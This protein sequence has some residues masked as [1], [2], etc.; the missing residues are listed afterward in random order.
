MWRLN[1][2]Y[3][4]NIENMLLF[5]LLDDDFGIF[6]DRKVYLKRKSMFVSWTSLSL[7]EQEEHVEYTLA[8]WKE[9]YTENKYNF[10]IDNL[11]IDD[12]TIIIDGIRTIINKLEKNTS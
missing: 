6:P 12:Y 5:H 10:M 9:P 3:S 8:L 1:N 11:R 4:K 7:E 2:G